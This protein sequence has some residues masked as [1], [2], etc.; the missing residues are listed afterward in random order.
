LFVK[1]AVKLFITWN[2]LHSPSSVCTLEQGIVNE[3]LRKR[4]PVASYF[5]E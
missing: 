3:M 5:H 4:K 2:Q 1:E